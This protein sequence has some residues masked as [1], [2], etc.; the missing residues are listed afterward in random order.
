VETEYNICENKITVVVT[1]TLI[2][3]FPN[4]YIS[5]FV[6]CSEDLENVSILQSYFQP[7]VYNQTTKSKIQQ[8]ARSYKNWQCGKTW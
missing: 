8:T 7:V 2:E 4:Y 5:N 1:N 6:I 3:E